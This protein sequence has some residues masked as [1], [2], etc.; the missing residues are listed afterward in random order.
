MTTALE[1]GDYLI[2]VDESGD[3]GL[4]SIDPEF[5]VFS[6]VFVIIKKTDYLQT[7]V[8]SFQYLKMK[9]WGHDQVIL[10]EHEIR[11]EK[12]HFGILRTDASLR[13]EFMADLTTIIKDSPFQYVASVI[14]KDKL[15]KQYA[16]PFSP[17]QI[18]LLFC[19]ER[20]L[21]ILIRHG[22]TGK[23][24]HILIEGRGKKEDKELELEFRR[25]CDNQGNWGYK[26]TDFRRILFNMICIDKKS[27]SS[28][29]Q[30][31]DLI[32]RPIALKN[33]RPQQENKT[34]EILNEKNGGTKCFPRSTKN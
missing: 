4:K 17:Y 22:Q 29:L 13:A 12:G 26:P 27:N 11:K 19:M 33:L 30:L 7:I 31:A 15:V 10:H 25:I 1:F 23:S 20:A 6:L 34:Y 8:P 32:A 9:Y 5:P 28:G 16:S 18:G 21:E 14:H 3:H 2:F 24:S